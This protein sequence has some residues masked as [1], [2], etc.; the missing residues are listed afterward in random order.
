[1]NISEENILVKD[2]TMRVAMPIWESRVSPVFDTAKQVLIV[3]IDRGEVASQFVLPLREKFIPRR[4]IFLGRRQVEILICGG[5][6]VYLARLVN[7]QGIQVVPGIEGTADEVL[8]AF[9]QGNIPSPRFLMA[10]W[11]GWE[12]KIYP[13]DRVKGM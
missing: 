4:A 5:I 6:S 8:K 12:R 1:M 13:E 10:G 7:A 11:R 3:D 9:C 2:I